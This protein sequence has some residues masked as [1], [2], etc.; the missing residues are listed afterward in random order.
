MHKTNLDPDIEDRIIASRGPD[1]TFA[2]HLDPATTALL[3]IDLQNG[4]MEPGALIEVPMARSVVDHVNSLSAALRAAGGKVAYSRYTADLSE[5][6][7]WNSFLNR[8][9]SPEKSEAQLKEF[10]PGAHGHALWDGLDV[11]DGDYTF[12][13]TRFS[14]LTPG[15]S[16]LL[17][18]LE[19]NAIETVII[20][21][22][23]SN[24]CCESTARDAFQYG[25]DVIFVTDAN[26]TVTDD[27]HRAT[28]HNMG[29]LF[30]ELADTETV[31][32]VLAPELAIAETA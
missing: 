26:A 24:C 15:T 7:P 11:Q 8:F 27:E 16:P 29:M 21:G 28:L 18:W 19:D 9:L 4:F 5:P 25:Y 31:C 22:T 10:A 30:A 1:S 20:T 6:K 13:K 2:K 14:C 23:L 3:V 32:N 17:G 12:D